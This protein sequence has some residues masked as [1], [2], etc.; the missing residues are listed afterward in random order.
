MV[1]LFASREARE[2]RSTSTGNDQ[3]TLLAY[4]ATAIDADHVILS[5]H[6]WEPPV[7]SC[8][9]F[10]FLTVFNNFCWHDDCLTDPLLPS[11]VHV[12]AIAV[13]T[14]QPVITSA[15]V[16]SR[17]SLTD[18]DLKMHVYKKALQAIIYPIS[19]T[20]PHKFTVNC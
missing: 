9:F 17:A 5:L 16:S 18:E 4:Q 11:L 13:M 8:S 19:C 3:R 12:Q 10:T 1:T 15:L 14:R 20:T 6:L 7:H 2:R